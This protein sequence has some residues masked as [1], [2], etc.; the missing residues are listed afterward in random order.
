MIKIDK[1]LDSIC[2]LG[3]TIPHLK[4]KLFD[5]VINTLLH[6]K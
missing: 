3:L 6:K 2:S 4:Q 1:C 5:S